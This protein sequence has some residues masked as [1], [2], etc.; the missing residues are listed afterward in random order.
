MAREFLPYDLDQQYL[1]PPSLR[2][3]VPEGHLIWFLSDLVDSLDLSAILSPYDTRET[4]GR[5]GYHPVMMTKLLL[6]AYAVGKPSSRKIE[7]ACWEEVPFRV[8]SGDQHPDHTS[9]SEFRRHQLGALAGLFV[10]VLMLCKDANL[11]KLGHVALDGTKVLAN[12]SKHKAM[13]YGRMCAA[14]EELEREVARLLQEAERVDAKEDALYGDARG[15]ELPPELA[16]RES[17]LEWIRKAKAALEAEAKEKAKAEQKAA[18]ECQE[19]RE[20]KDVAD[21]KKV[22]GRPPTTRDPEAALPKAKDQRNFTDPESRIM[23]DGATGS[24]VQAYNAH[25]AVD[26]EAQIILAASVTQKANDKQAFL[27]MLE[28]IESHLSEL[29]DN[30][31]ADSGFFCERNLSD[32]RF[33]GV[34]CYV[35]PERNVKTQVAGAMRDKLESKDGDAVYRK[36]KSTVEPVFGQIKEA[37]GFRRFSLRGFAAASNEWQLI[38]L[39]H[40]LLKLYRAGASPSFA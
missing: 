17:R 21:G 12:A 32:T 37:R 20:A 28:E 25:A 8:L 4:R 16:R 36:R 35:P 38:C 31:T 9:I 29:P 24:F 10:Q 22:R 33:T 14:E 7:R 13:S 26:E 11:V 18:N 6:Y 3:W 5:A 15:D 23:K 39:T 30:V 1:L 27:P 34:E 40:N 19:E 2:D